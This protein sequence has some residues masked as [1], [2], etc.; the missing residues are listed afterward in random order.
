MIHSVRVVASIISNFSVF[1]ISS[2]KEVK[3]SKYIQKILYFS[4][5]SRRKSVFS[6]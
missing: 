4:F 6:P 3:L 1:S 2:S 5:N